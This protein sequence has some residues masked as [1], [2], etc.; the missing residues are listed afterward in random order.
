MSKKILCLHGWGA[1]KESFTELRAALEGSD[2]AL[3]TPDLPGF[4]DEPEP[5]H[6][7]TN[8]DYADWVINWVVES[9][10]LKEESEWY[11]LGH[12]AG[13][14]IVIKLL[15]D[16]L[17]T[18]NSQLSTPKH[19]FLCAAAGL[20]RRRHVKRVVGLVISKSGKHLLSVPGLKKLQPI[21]RKL[22]YKLIRVHDY[23]KASEV[24]KQTLI[25]VTKED[26]HPLLKKIST[27]VDLF[28]GTDDGMTPYG[29]AV[30]MDAE[31]PNSKL[32][33]YKGVHH[34]VHRD[35]ASEIAEVIRERILQ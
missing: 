31:I 34:R 10:K 9:G 7:F 8:D 30:I 22:L 21:A 14:R 26:L 18:L 2:I 19:A 20:R 25:N 29:D 3:I 6:A 23:E 24:M 33:S 35:R 5:D 13:G 28:W 4:G 27:P 15:T 12:S 17:S 16:K 1:S 32:H 11:I